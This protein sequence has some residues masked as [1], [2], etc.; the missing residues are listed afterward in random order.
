VSVAGLPQVVSLVPRRF[1]D[2]AWSGVPRFDFELRRIFPGMLS[3]RLGL[4]PRWVLRRMRALRR[5]GVVVVT[6]SE[7]SLFVPG[8][9]RTIVVHHGCAQT[10]FD[11]DPRWR[12]PGPR[13]TCLAQRLMYRRPNRW[14]VAPARWTAREFSAHHGVPEAALIPNW[15]E[16][17][18]RG[19]RRGARPVVLGDWRNFNK[20]SRAVPALRRRL[21]GVEFR[22]LACTYATRG[23]AYAAA[24]AYLCLS[25]S[26]GGSYSVSD[27]EAADLPIV[28]TDVGNYLE[29][30]ASRVVPWGRRDDPDVVAP[31]LE[32]ALASPRGPSF[33]ESWTFT[34]WR[35][36]WRR[37][38]ERVADSPAAPPLHAG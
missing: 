34:A 33:F 11:R 25:L 10:H 15:V 35:D 1:E 16:P 14:Y 26:E 9:V 30:A 7:E 23:E 24:D 31:E 28:T 19:A 29:Y 37:L 20:G 3:L 36:A 27:A 6:G 2:G 13:W 18:A 21:P 4:D 32:A 12:G 38:V 8:R 5:P 22:P 17:L